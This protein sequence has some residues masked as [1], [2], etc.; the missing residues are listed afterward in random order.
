MSTDTIELA[1]P[2][3][4]PGDTVWW[5]W[6][7]I[8]TNDPLPAMVVL[9]DQRSGICT[10]RVFTPDGD[11]RVKGCRHRDDRERMDNHTFHSG[12]WAEIPPLDD[13]DA[14]V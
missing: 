8:D 11:Q 3:L 9:C 1:Y 2:R 12:Y 10:L 4:R 5:W 6:R 13:D 14:G 7:G